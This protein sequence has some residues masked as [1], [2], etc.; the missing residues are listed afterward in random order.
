M[1]RPS[2]RSNVELTKRFNAATR[3]RFSGLFFFVYVLFFCAFPSRGQDAFVHQSSVQSL[4]GQFVIGPAPQFSWLRRRDDLTTNADLIRLEPA[5][6]AISA[7]RFKDSLWRQIGLSPRSSWRGK[8][9]VAVHA[10]RSLD[11]EVTIAAIPFLNV[12]NYRVDFPDLILR[13]RFARS[14]ATVLLLEIANRN[15]PV[16]GRSAEIPAWLADGLAQQTLVDSGG[17]IILSSPTK[18][19]NG[20]PQ[21][22]LD[23]KERGLDA[24]ARARGILQNS[25]ALIFDQLSWPTD[26]QI[27]GE[28][29]GVYLAS[30]QLFVRELLALK[31]GSAKMQNFLAQL[32]AD[33]NWQTAFYSA[34]REN[35]SRPLDVEKWWS[36]RVINFAASSHSAR[37]SFANSAENLAEILT[38]PVDY[39]GDANALP[40]RAQI[41]LQAAIGN[42]DAAQQAKIFQVKMRDLELAQL[43]LA[44]PFNDLAGE[45]RKILVNYLG[46]ATGIASAETFR[47]PRAMV[48]KT[49]ARDTLKKL[50]LLDA[51]RQKAQAATYISGIGR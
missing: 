36:L 41:S 32:P 46:T 48:K 4:S 28:D 7:E 42:L 34:F 23:E 22:S 1:I 29:G 33:Y 35:F 31:N 45:Y 21:S 13:N 27:N 6:L 11:E 20:F 3:Q 38:V 15:A 39:R 8:I 25:P 44:R 14:L 16:N 26:V 9:F 40:V 37:W 51:Q 49:S 10:A 43:R 24:L 17:K 5:L 19:V 18:T 12:W 47:N 50:E 2:K 30:A